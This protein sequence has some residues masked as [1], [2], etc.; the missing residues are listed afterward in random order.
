VCERDDAA[1]VDPQLCSAL[2]REELVAICAAA[3]G[4]QISAVRA[5]LSGLDRAKLVAEAAK[6]LGR[7]SGESLAVSELSI[8]AAR[9]VLTLRD[10]PFDDLL[11][12]SELCSRVE[13]CH[14]G[15]CARLPTK[16]LKSML[17]AEGLGDEIFVDKAVLVRRLMA[18]RAL[19]RQAAQ[20]R[21]EQTPLPPPVSATPLRPAAPPLAPPSAQPRPARPG[22]RGSP[23]PDEQSGGCQCNI[24]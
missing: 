9:A 18:V 2:S 6:Q 14:R 11:E 1:A 5:Q 7:S 22:F 12:K 20:R 17:R 13:Q 4:L 3:N 19:K 8:R 10:I 21:A 24:C 15:A 23:Q 16:L